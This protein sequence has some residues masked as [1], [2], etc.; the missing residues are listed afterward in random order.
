[1]KWDVW[2]ALP[3]PR[4]RNDIPV[5]LLFLLGT[6][7]VLGFLFFLSSPSFPVFAT[8]E[9]IA[10]NQKTEIDR[11]PV[12]LVLTPDGKWLL[13]ANQTSSTVSLVNIKSGKVV[14]EVACGKR[15]SGLALTPDGRRVLV[16]G[17]YGGDVTIFALKENN[18]EKMGSVYL[19][20]E[21]RGVVVSP[22]GKLAY[23]ALETGNAVAVVDLQA[24]K[25]VDRI[26]V[27]RWPRYLALT[28]D[29]KRLAVS[30]SGDGGVAV[31]DT[32]AKKRLFLNDFAGI[33]VGHMQTSADG[34]F[35]YAPWMVYRLNPITTNNI[36][37]GWVLAS[38]IARVRLDEKVRREALELDKRGEAIADP[39]GLA[40]SP[41]EKTIVVSASG[42]H[43]LL[44]FRAA[45]LPWKARGGRDHIPPELLRDDNRFYRIHVG[46]RP[47]IVRF[48][49]DNHT[50]YVANYLLNAVQV[51]DLKN[52]KVAQTISL[53]GPK[54]PSLVRKGEAI[55][56]DGQR[57][58]DQWYSCHTCHYEGHTNSV[59]MDTRNDGRF[60]NYK[61]VLSLRNVTHTGPWTW[62]GWQKDLNAAMRRSLRD[63][64]LTQM[65]TTDGDVQAM[66]A[67]LKTLKS[68]PSPFLN[69]DGSLTAAA[70]RGKRVFASTKAGCS[71]CHRG[72]YFTDGRIHDVGTGE[73]SDYY[74]GYNTPSLLGVH[75]KVLLLHDGRA[76]SMEEALRGAHNPQRVTGEGELT[77]QEMRDLIAYLKSL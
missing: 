12:D 28:P 62:H 75:S 69:R 7:L 43:E 63:T 72:P 51:I 39:H 2:G 22:D 36:R 10:Q 21:P 70:Q 16:T 48:G 3:F 49:R 5:S 46:G 38:R 57:S 58:L 14:A 18:L 15:P 4:S 61:T 54:E 25:D 56:Y 65:R 20:F 30:V 1:M 19:G 67:F 33:N 71:R 60:G 11:S 17:T 77:A 13:T 42:S 50:V 34:K 26:G 6:V 76:P 66:V 31:V 37:I 9:T 8:Q 47:M 41:D 23:V 27:G 73:D 29:G 45:G 35:V 52:R 53:G 32:V 55:F 74:K 68:P 44:V 64:M 40:L 59:A 24:L